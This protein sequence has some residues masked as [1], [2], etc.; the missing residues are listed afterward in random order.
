MKLLRCLFAILG[1]VAL[2]SLGTAADPA[3]GKKK[4]F[5]DDFKGPLV[6]PELLAK[7]KFTPEQKAKVDALAAEFD[8][9]NDEAIAKAK[10]DASK[11]TDD[12]K[13]AKADGDKAAMKKANGDLKDLRLNLTK[14]RKEY[15]AKFLEML[16][17]E[18]KKSYDNARA[19]VPE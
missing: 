2:V 7:I 1:L 10:D 12:L 9:K 5:G 4:A 14:L 3:K 6:L 11:A 18:Q 17:E 8:K 13:K 16:T 15:D 19:G